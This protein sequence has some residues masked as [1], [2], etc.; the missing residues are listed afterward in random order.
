MSRNLLEVAGSE[1]APL[2]KQ[3]ES[4][5]IDSQPVAAMMADRKNTSN[6]KKMEFVLNGN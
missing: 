4:A 6:E 5:T 2:N 1:I 3:G